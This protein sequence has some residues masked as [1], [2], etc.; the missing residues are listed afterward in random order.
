MTTCKTQKLK[1]GLLY[2]KL[3]FVLCCL[4]WTTNSLLAQSHRNRWNFE[5]YFPKNYFYKDT[6]NNK[7]NSKV[8][9][10]VFYM[11]LADIQPL[12]DIQLQEA[13][14]VVRLNYFP[15]FA[16]PLFIEIRQGNGQTILYWQK[17]KAIRGYVEHTTHNAIRETGYVDVT[18]KYY[19]GN[20]WE[21]GVLDSGN[22]RL[23]SLEWQQ[24]QKN[25]EELDFIH[26][27]H[28]FSYGGFL[29][30]YILE[31]LD[32][33]SMIS[34]YS[35]LPYKV[36]ENH[37]IES[38]VSLVD[39]AYEDMDI[40]YSNDKDVIKP[41]Y[42]GGESA[43]NQFVEQS[44]AYP[45]DALR[46]WVEYT[47]SVQAVIEKDGSVGFVRDVSWPK[48]D[49]GFAEELIRVVKSMPQ[50]KP[51]TKDNK[52]VRYY[53]TI[54]YKFTLP[55][56]I[57][58][59]YGNPILETHRDSVRW[60]EIE[61]CHRK[62]IKNPGDIEA[63]LRMGHCYYREFILEHPSENH[64][65]KWLIEDDEKS[66]DSSAVV[67]HPADSALKY[68]YQT[69]QL[70]PD[71][72]TIQN[73]YVPVLQLEQYLHKPHNVLVELP[74]D[75]V[76]GVHLPYSYLIN[77]PKDGQFYIGTDYYGAVESSYF[78]V[79]YFS[80]ILAKM[81]EPVIF[82]EFLQDD[83]TI[84]R[85]SFY[86]SFHPPVSFRVMK[87]KRKVTLYWKILHTEY[88]QNNWNEIASTVV[89]GHRKMTAAQYDQFMEYVNEL[90]MDE[91][92][93]SYYLPIHDG[94]QWLIEQKNDTNFTAFFT[95]VA[96]KKIKNVFAYF[97]K[98]S[99]V[100]IDYLKD[101]Y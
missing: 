56:D 99:K 70:N 61:A 14:V 88:D 36:N 43:C 8:G 80:Q 27:P 92:S 25:L 34:Y 57:R 1:H 87:N 78:W 86:P 68:F 75:T 16:H 89:E 40:Y 4:L 100:K 67:S 15:K 53:E 37:L 26:Y 23:S 3:W 48:S 101:Y 42:P 46:D 22:R 82:N 52:A 7:D 65:V 66:V 32:E 69:M 9:E 41:V 18:E 72:Y 58:P 35:A 94:A 95:N 10:A 84:F 33:Q 31:Y 49:Y 90:R 47:A 96:G 11:R 83:E 97:I 17:G 55:P 60:E 24:I 79:D 59:Q 45:V 20:S 21:K 64:E 63:T 28:A 19:Y 71:A 73:I 51:A 93:R 38:L 91:R 6:E 50:W 76:E 74:M 13:E 62:L 30:P 85:F 5:D 98:I 54:S 2:N 12:R 29:D 44:I 81:R 77:R 39:S